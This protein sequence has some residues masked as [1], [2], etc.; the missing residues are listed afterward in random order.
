MKTDGHTDGFQFDIMVSKGG[1]MISLILAAVVSTNVCSTCS[2]LGKVY[3]TCPACR[4]K[5]VI[6]KRIQSATKTA[7]NGGGVVACTKCCKGFASRS[8]KGSGE[9]LVRCPDCRGSSK[10]AAKKV[11]Y[12]RLKNN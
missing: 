8:S 6:E 9:V 2:G 10:A 7:L 1:Y 4:G 3:I 5:G 12:N 11:Q